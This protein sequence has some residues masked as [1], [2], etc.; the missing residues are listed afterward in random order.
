MPWSH[1]L[2]GATR[3]VRSDT[4]S[5][6]GSGEWRANFL[7]ARR[8]C[9]AREPMAKPLRKPMHTACASPIYGMRFD[10]FLMRKT[11]RVKRKDRATDS[12]WR[13]A[14][15]N[16]EAL[17]STAAEVL[18]SRHVEQ[19]NYRRCCLR[20]DSQHLFCTLHRGKLS[21][22]KYRYLSPPNQDLHYEPPTDT[23]REHD[24]EPTAPT[25]W[26]FLRDR[27]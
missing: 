18:S 4:H 7:H 16:P 19:S 26:R 15:A 5:R 6:R 24:R 20:A 13:D 21:H 3:G 1:S 8:P 14:S 27:Q 9:L 25:R 23:L 2:P 22:K 17:P 10:R 11:R 12:G